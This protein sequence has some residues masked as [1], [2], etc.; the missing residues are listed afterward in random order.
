MSKRGRLATGVSSGPIFLTK[1][2]ETK[3]QN[4]TNPLKK[5]KASQNSRLVLVMGNKFCPIP[6]QMSNAVK[7][8]LND[9]DL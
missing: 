1:K 5:T 7:E 2:Q 4:S 9:A 6:S 8:N 3:K